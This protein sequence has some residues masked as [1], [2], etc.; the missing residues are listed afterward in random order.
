M[1]ESGDRPEEN[2][3]QRT[4]NLTLAAVA[5]QVGCLTVGVIIVAL[6]FGLWLDNRLGTLPWFTIGFLL[7]S[8]PVTI[9]LMFRVVRTATSKMKFTSSSES[10]TPSEEAEIGRKDDA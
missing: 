5:G 9:I 8:V 3:S 10:D 6:L 2:R 7:V 1:N 4:L